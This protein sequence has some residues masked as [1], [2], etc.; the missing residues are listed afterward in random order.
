MRFAVGTTIPVLLLFFTSIYNEPIVASPIAER[1]GEG[2]FFCKPP[3]WEYGLPRACALYAILDHV[4]SCCT[5][6]NSLFDVFRSCF[7]VFRFTHA[8]PLEFNAMRAVD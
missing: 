5:P 7:F 1:I 3:L 4:F 8:F 2:S 6:Q